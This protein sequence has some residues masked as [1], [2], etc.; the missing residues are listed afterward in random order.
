MPVAP[1][2]EKKFLAVPEFSQVLP[3]ISKGFFEKN[4]VR[5]SGFRESRFPNKS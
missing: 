3:S 1:G 2:S 4:P 5:R